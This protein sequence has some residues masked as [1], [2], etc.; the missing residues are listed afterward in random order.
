MMLDCHRMAQSIKAIVTAATLNATANCDSLAG[1][2]KRRNNFIIDL[3]P[4]THEPFFL[5]HTPKLRGGRKDLQAAA[6]YEHFGKR[7]AKSSGKLSK[8]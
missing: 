7:R 6:F 4:R 5:V 3:S 8:L 1:S 2:P